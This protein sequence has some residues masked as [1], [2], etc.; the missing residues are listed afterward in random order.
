MNILVE[1]FFLN[2]NPKQYSDSWGVSMDLR[3][4]VLSALRQLV[5]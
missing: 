5:L 2:R 1:T 4:A 3:S